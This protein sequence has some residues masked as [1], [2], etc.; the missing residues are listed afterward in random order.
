MVLCI[1]EDCAYLPSVRSI[2]VVMID[3]RAVLHFVPWQTPQK[4]C[5]PF[6]REF[7]GGSLGSDIYEDLERIR[8]Y[9]FQNLR[10]ARK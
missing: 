4:I 1:A 7:I 3:K 6:G 9:G 5:N 8:P 2:D 10:L